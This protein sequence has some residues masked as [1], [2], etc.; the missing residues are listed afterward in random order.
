M[1]STNDMLKAMK[2][3]PSKVLADSEKSNVADTLKKPTK[4]SFSENMADAVENC[5]NI[6]SSKRNTL[7]K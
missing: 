7:G 4:S 2:P 1:A 6:G 3:S 5:L